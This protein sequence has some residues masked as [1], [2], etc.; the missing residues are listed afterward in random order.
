[1]TTAIHKEDTE[2]ALHLLTRGEPDAIVEIRLLGRKKKT[3]IMSGYFDP[4]AFST[5]AKLLE[6]LLR[7]NEYN[8]YVTMNGL[9]TGLLSR[10]YRRFEKYPPN[11]TTDREVLKYRWI[12]M[13]FD[14]VRPSGINATDEEKQTSIELADTVKAFC[15]NKLKMQE[16][17]ECA[18]GNGVHHLYPF[19]VSVNEKNIAFVKSL[20]N[21]LAREFNNER[22]KLDT[23]NFN[24]AR[25]T[26]LY[27]TLSGKGDNTAERPHRFSKITYIPNALE[28]NHE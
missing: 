16:P 1:M 14:P 18:S 7:N 23:A 28:A 10:Y 17:L 13:D 21:N 4:P 19:D 27:G 8:C 11:T 5:A 22:C 26:K 2:K 20:L 15:I 6:T 3:D 12:L 24:P 9:H 25:I